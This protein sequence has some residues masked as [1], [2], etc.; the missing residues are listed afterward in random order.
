VVRGR[1]F[2][3]LISWLQPLSSGALRSSFKRLLM[4]RGG[5]KSERSAFLRLASQPL[6]FAAKMKASSHCYTLPDVILVVVDPR[7]Q[8]A[9][10]A[11][12]Q[13]LDG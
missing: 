13:F 2:R 1:F 12:S 5:L 9:A 6:S 10:R 7:H 8:V 11:E 4:A 3:N